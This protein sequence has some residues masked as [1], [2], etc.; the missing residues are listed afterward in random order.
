MD[1]LAALARAHG[2]ALIEDCAQAHGAE[3]RGRPVG[4][5]GDVAAWSF[6][7]DKI[8][9]LGGEGGAVT[10]DDEQIWSHIWSL[11]DH[12][13]SYEAVYL[14]K[15]PPGFRW[16]HES[17]GSNWRITEMQSAMG[18]VLLRR[19]PAW[20]E[21]RRA[22]AAMLRTG[23]ERLTALRTPVPPAHLTHAYYKFYTFVRPDALKAAWDRDRIMN[24]VTAQGV[25]CLSGSCSE[26]YLEKAMQ[27]AGLAP[28]ERLLNARELGETSLMFLVHPTLG[29]AEM[30]RTVSVVERT[31]TEATR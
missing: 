14:R 8:L 10:T 18:R 20:S 21:A 25:A 31:L 6:C 28:T 17:F 16:L 11:K 27:D 5:L 9:T 29:P 2:I 7:Q 12:G 1:S 4:G 22:N 15:H 30:D 3:Y 13:K 26:V 24:E 23:F 19:L